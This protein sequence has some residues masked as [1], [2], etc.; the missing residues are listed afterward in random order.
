M[1]GALG[2]AGVALLA[3]V[4]ALPGAQAWVAIGGPT[5]S[6]E[7]ELMDCGP[8]EDSIPILDPGCPMVGAGGFPPEPNID[9]DCI[10]EP[11]SPP[12]EPAA[13]P[14]PPEGDP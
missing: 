2:V 14:N 11:P 7:D 4:A 12:D 3:A 1:R 8:L 6:C 13:F 5:S 9:P 10:G